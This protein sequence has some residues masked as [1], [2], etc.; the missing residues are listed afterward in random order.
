MRVVSARPD[1][2]Y[3]WN[4]ARASVGEVNRNFTLGIGRC[5]SRPRQRCSLQTPRLLLGC[6]GIV[7]LRTAVHLALVIFSP[8]LFLLPSNLR[9]SAGYQR[10]VVVVLVVVIIVAVV[11]VV[12]VVAV[13]DILRVY[14]Q[15]VDPLL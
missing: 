1:A 14:I 7:S 8:G 15:P 13:V 3:R 11:V 4:R 9:I 12:V 10:V 5:R 2:G 6:V